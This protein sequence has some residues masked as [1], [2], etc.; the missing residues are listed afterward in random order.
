MRRSRNFALEIASFETGKNPRSLT[1]LSGLDFGISREEGP[2]RHS[3][4]YIIV[5]AEAG[6]WPTPNFPNFQNGHKMA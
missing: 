4:F 2:I 5:N 1:P 3:A 6:K